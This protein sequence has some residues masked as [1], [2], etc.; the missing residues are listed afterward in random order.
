MKAKY[1]KA[2]KELESLGCPVLPGGNWSAGSIFEISGESGKDAPNGLPWADYWAGGCQ[3]F[4]VNK[5]V[6]EVLASAGLFA[7]W[8][9]AGVLGV[10]PA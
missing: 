3:D 2:L 1:E 6:D 7:E 8:I 9:N 4:G 10:Y 5:K